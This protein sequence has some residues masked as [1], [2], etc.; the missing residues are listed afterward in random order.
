MNHSLIETIEI[1]LTDFP[2]VK[3][4]DLDTLQVNL[5]YK[6]NMSC[7]HCHVSA[8]PYRKEMMSA[9]TVDLIF[10]VLKKRGIKTLDLTGGAPEMHDLFRDIV[11]RATAMGVHVIDRCNLTILFEEGYSDLAQFLASHGVEVVASLPCY[12]SENVD[13]QRGKGVFD[14]SILGLQKLNALGYGKPGSGLNLNLV[15]NPLG[16]SLPPSQSD[17]EVVYKRELKHHFDIQFN[18][19]YALANMPVNR[20]KSILV[21]KEKYHEYMSLLKTNFHQGNMSSLM[22]RSL[23]SVDWQGNLYDCDFNQQLGLHLGGE[24]VSHLRDLLTNNISQD[25]VSVADHCYGCTAGQGSSCG[26]AF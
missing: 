2:P 20:F 18:Q 4:S 15:Y 26:G 1:G 9:N 11:V 8:G 7:Q 14:K 16:A 3:R 22:C 6:C 25:P 12:S 13:K 10:P 19:L 23:V 21:A 24:K 17:L 5:G